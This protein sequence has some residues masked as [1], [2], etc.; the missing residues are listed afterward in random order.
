MVI[1]TWAS[2]GGTV[3][4]GS[5]DLAFEWISPESWNEVPVRDGIT[6]SRLRTLDLAGGD[7]TVN[8]VEIEPDRGWDF[9]PW[10]HGGCATVP[11]EAR[12]I[13]AIVG[14]N[15]GFFGSGCETLDLLRV[16]GSLYSTNTM[17]GYEQ[18][19]MGWNDGTDPRFSWIGYDTDWPGVR[20]AMGGHP[21]LVLDGVGLAEVLPGETVWSSTDWSAHPR[22]AVGIDSSGTWM[23]LTVDGRTAAGDGMTNQALAELFEDL[24]AVEAIGMDGGGSTQ[25]VVRDCWLGDVVNSPSDDG[26]SGHSGERSVGSG[27]YVR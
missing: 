19:S 10:D 5:Y 12:D 7:Q 13:G 1:D 14:I 27:L 8:L 2:S 20:N 23:L 21:S 18:R 3:Y 25:M 26:S 17:T 4:A 16:D 24:G 6:W 15:G 22:T 9:Q 11:N